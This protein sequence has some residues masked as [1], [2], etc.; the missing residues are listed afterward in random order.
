MFALVTRTVE[1]A[2]AAYRV[3]NDRGTWGLSN[4]DVVA[5]LSITVEC[6]CVHMTGVD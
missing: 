5:S 6:V 2:I 3:L 1:L 4:E